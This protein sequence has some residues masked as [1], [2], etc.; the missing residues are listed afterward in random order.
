MD[1]EKSRSFRLNLDAVSIPETGQNSGE[2]ENS[3]KAFWR[4]VSGIY[5]K[6]IHKD[7]AAYERVYALI[8]EKVKG[9]E[10]LELATGTGLIARNIAEWSARVVA[11]D[12]SPAM[13]ERAKKLASH[14]GLSFEVQDACDLPYGDA[15]FDV[16]IISNALHIMPRPERALAEILRVLRPDGILIAPTF[17]HAEMGRAARIKSGIM[18]AFG[19]PLGH[20]WTPESYRAFLEANGFAPLKLEVIASTFPLSYL[21][22]NKKGGARS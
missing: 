3:G 8:R 22:C 18:R 19:F 2:R 17:T 12:F 11:T 5:E 7:R 4:A 21:E 13:I 14:E 15:S 1:S 20:A 6:I 10:V 16:V 9:R